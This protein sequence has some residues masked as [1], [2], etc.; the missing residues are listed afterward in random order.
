MKLPRA[1]RQLMHRRIVMVASVVLAA[2]VVLAIGAPTV[3]LDEG[4]TRTVDYFRQFV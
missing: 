3:A 1:L 2:I 4:L